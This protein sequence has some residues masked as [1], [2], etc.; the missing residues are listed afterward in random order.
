MAREGTV[1]VVSSVQ[2][3]P[4]GECLPLEGCRCLLYP[5]FIAV[6]FGGTPSTV[7]FGNFTLKACCPIAVVVVIRSQFVYDRL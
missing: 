5:T 7:H 4:T 3:P 1:V 6:R 2:R